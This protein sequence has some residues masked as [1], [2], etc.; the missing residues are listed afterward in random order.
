MT[1]VQ[2]KKLNDLAAQGA[3]NIRRQNGSRSRSGTRGN[4]R[5]NDDKGDWL[6]GAE[7]VLH[8]A[9]AQVHRLGCWPCNS[10]NTTQPVAHAA[11]QLV[12]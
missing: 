2:Q 9:S 12:G 5:M 3:K 11:A 7:V 6:A 1:D 10:T 4:E 8:Q